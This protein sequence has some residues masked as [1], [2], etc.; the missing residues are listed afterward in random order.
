MNEK[1][2]YLKMMRGSEIKNIT[3]NVPGKEGVVQIGFDEFII[4]VPEDTLQVYP[5]LLGVKLR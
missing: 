5:I 3:T 2:A 4:E 1:L